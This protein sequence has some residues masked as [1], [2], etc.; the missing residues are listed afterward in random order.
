MSQQE[1]PNLLT[2]TVSSLYIHVPF[3]QSKCHYCDF[4][5]LAGA[6]S[7][8]V[9]VWHETIKVEL[10][11]LSREAESNGVSILP[12]ET[13]YYGGGTPSLLPF[14]FLA[15]E[16]ELCRE[17]FGIAETAEIT[18]EANPEQ[19]KTE[20]TAA[21]WLTIGFNRL[22]IGLQSASDHLLRI[23]GRRHNK[24]DAFRAVCFA[25]EAGF[26]N[27]SADLISG[28]PDAQMS[29]IEETLAFIDNLP[30]TH[31]S[32]YALDVPHDSYFAKM[33]AADCSRFPD[34]RLE[35]EM[36]HH[37]REVLIDRG[38]NHYE[39]SNF[40]L[41]SFQS[42]HNTVYWRAEPY[43]AAGPSASSYLAGIRRSNPA[44]LMEWKKTVLEDG[45][46]SADTVT[47]IISEEEAA[48]E[49]ILL[50]LRLLSGVKAKDFQQRHSRDYRQLF[51][52][53]IK[54]LSQ[55]GLLNFDGDTLRLTH[56][57][58]DFCNI[59]FREFV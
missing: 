28:L 55:A 11:R 58:E 30:L 25:H 9:Q 34:D 10:Q 42:R 16:L 14:E 33:L 32:C 51:A 6:D 48:R 43:L 41:D 53:Q 5:S 29:D 50:G 52:G 46:F 40:A 22:S 44:S 17:L 56:E 4:Y 35:R 37:I 59:V 36:F 54:K 49:S 3:C 24:E 15:E 45:P 38:F 57:G 39:I 21:E 18:L 27:I 19:I 8:L 1:I 23:M 20:E 31:L 26:R 13:I 2:G 7:Q 47:E 12:L